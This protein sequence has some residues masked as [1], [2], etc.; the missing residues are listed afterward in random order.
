MFSLF[1]KKIEKAELCFNTDIHCHIVPGNDDGSPDV[2]TSVELVERMKGW[3]INRIIASPHVTQEAFENTPEIIGQALAPLKS[4]L[5]TKGID[6]E[7]SHS[8]EYRIDEFFL[9]QL[10]CG[11]IVSLPGN[12]LLVENSFLQEPWNL[13]KILFDLK[14]RGY[15]PILAHPERYYYY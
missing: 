15:K 2:T 8:A 1:K 6:V 12:Y 9:S 11:N 13:D 7:L 3:G 10:E 5:E 14:V 4:E